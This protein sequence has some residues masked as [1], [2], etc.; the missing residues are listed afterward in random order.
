[1]SDHPIAH[2]REIS[3]GTFAPP[4]DLAEHLREVAKLGQEFAAPFH[5]SEWAYL[6][7]IWHDLG[8]YQPRFQSYIA[9]A[10]GYDPD[11]HI[12]GRLGKVPHSTAGTL[13]A[14]D[15]FGATG[16]VLAMMCS[17]IEAK[18]RIGRSKAESLGTRVWKP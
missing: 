9:R 1:M 8:K 4:H 2:V 10:S 17:E 11:A 14:Y 12:E 3:P 16:R 7:G 5:S 6:A 13:L 15:K 18:R